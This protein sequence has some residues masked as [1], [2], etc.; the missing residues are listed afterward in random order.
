MNPPSFTLS[1]GTRACHCPASHRHSRAP[2]FSLTQALSPGQH[3]LGTELQPR[4]SQLDPSLSS[5]THNFARASPGSCA[6]WAS[7]SFLY[8]NAL[9]RLN[10]SQVTGCRTGGGLGARGRAGLGC[11]GARVSHWGFSGPWHK[12]RSEGDGLS[13]RAQAT[14]LHISLRQV[15]HARSPHLGDVV[16]GGTS[17]TA[18][19]AVV[20]R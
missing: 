13:S 19:W 18:L 9:G 5:G 17:A 14:G 8:T 1:P 10:D 4:V 15:A 20:L 12:R 16:V 11:R 6:T 3:E 7:V 2:S